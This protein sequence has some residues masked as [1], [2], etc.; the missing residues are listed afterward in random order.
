MV[1]FIETSDES[2]KLQTHITCRASARNI[3]GTVSGDSRTSFFFH[4]NIRPG[5]LIKEHE[6]FAY[7]FKFAKKIEI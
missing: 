5:N 7:K 3:K 6:P 4:L 2:A 1:F